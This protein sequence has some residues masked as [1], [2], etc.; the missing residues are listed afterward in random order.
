MRLDAWPTLPRTG[1][2]RLYTSW[3]TVVSGL[4]RLWSFDWKNLDL[5]RGR[6]T[7]EGQPVADAAREP[8]CTYPG[9]R[10]D[11]FLRI[12]TSKWQLCLKPF[13]RGSRLRQSCGRG[14]GPV[15]RAFAVGAGGF[16]PP[17][18]SASRKRSPPELSARYGDHTRGGDRN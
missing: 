17:T 3:P 18:S 2:G 12:G 13:G 11:S 7:V 14:K 9:R 10:V 4:A 6:V 8:D 16:E 1:T 15:T 5:L